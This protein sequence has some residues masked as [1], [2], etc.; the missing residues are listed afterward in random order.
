MNL[1]SRKLNLINW[2][3]SIQEE[4]VLT[5]MEKIQQET[6]D[7]WDNINSED[8]KSIK[9]GLEQLDKGDYMTHSQVRTKIQEKYNF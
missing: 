7:W 2:I 5:Q 8:K 3:S 4:N 6:N 1:E 9:D